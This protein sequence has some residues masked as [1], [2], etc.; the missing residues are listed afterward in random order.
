MSKQAQAA[1]GS[2]AAAK[3]PSAF[4]QMKPVQKILHVIKVT[5]FFVTFGFAF[6]NIL[7]DD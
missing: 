2:A 1:Q 3:A 6:H 4:K 7:R 5:L